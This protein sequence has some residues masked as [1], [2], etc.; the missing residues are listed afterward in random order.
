M[1]LLWGASQD[2]AGQYVGGFVAA[3]I[4]H[5]R[6]PAAFGAYAACG[7][8]S[9]AGALVGGVV[10]NNYLP[11]YGSIEASFAADRRDWLTRAVITA[12]LAYPFQQL[13]C[14]RLTAVTPRKAASARR[15]LE[16]FGFRRE[17]L[18]R[19]G[20]GSDDAVISGLLRA[21]WDQSPFNAGRVKDRQ[22]P[23]HAAAAA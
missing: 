22:A 15:F 10:F 20:F 18:V 13:G 17:G 23:A 12:M 14:Q 5:L 21:E 11:A 3:R 19:R 9:G 1:R 16:K 4:A 2:A 6:D 8:V 7:V